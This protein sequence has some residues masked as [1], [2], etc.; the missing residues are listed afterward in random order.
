MFSK[1]AFKGLHPHKQFIFSWNLVFSF[2]FVVEVNPSQATIGVNLNLLTFHESASKCFFAIIIQIEYD[3]IPSII[4]L[5]GHWTFE[6][7]YSCDWLIIAGNESSFHVFIIEYG[8]FE[9][10]V[11]IELNDYIT[12]FL[13]SSTKMG[14]F[15]LIDTFFWLGKAMKL[16]MMLLPLIS[17]TGSSISGSVILLMCPFL[18]EVTQEIPFD[19]HFSNI[20][21]M[22][23][24]LNYWHIILEA[25]KNGNETWMLLFPIHCLI[26]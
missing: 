19:Y 16:L 20:F 3:L 12:T 18:T 4:Q 9:P 25:W 7:F 23:W 2:D 6:R 17:K 13:T 26:I 10:K 14:C 1:S 15:T 8:N 22:G 5:Q 24:F 11:L 21:S